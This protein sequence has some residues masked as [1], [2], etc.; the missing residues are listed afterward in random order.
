M[1]TIYKCEICGRESINKDDIIECESV[2][3][4]NQLLNIG[5][6]I[7][8]DKN[9]QKEILHRD[10]QYS[11]TLNSIEMSTYNEIKRA[12]ECCDNIFIIK[13][14]IKDGHIIKYEL[15]F[16]TFGGNIKMST[17]YNNIYTFPI[18]S[19]NDE[20]NKILKLN[21]KDVM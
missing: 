3:Y 20:L 14:I 12:I 8:L 16:K 19:G 15:S 1:I 6:E 18:I 11:D 21:K 9:V 17:R 5:D 4:E 7:I 2:G 10:F 13:N